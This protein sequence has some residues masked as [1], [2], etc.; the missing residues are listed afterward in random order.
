[1]KK[2]SFSLALI[3]SVS[4]L[5]AQNDRE[6]HDNKNVPASVRQNFSKDNPAANNA[7][8]SKSNGRYHATFKKDDHD[9]DSYYDNRGQHLYNRTPWDR[10]QLPPDYDKRIR[11]RYHTNDY[12]VARIERP[13]NQSL[14][15][16]ILNIG[17]K[18][19]TVYTDEHG[20]TVRFTK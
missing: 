19:K 5:F 15:E 7:H 6:H 20:N 3:F 18:S 12:R 2:L 10:K 13:N 11:S 1:M 4:F 9:V 8:W 14:F 17:G 16:L